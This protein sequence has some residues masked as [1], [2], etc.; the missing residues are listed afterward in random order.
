MADSLPPL[1]FPADGEQAFHRELKRR[2]HAYLSGRDDHRFAD[3]ARWV[4]AIVLLL[5]CVGF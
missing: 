3:V 2:A 4:K 1:S 5:L